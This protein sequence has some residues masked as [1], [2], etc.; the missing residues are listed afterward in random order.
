[1]SQARS[2]SKSVRRRCAPC[3]CRRAVIR[4]ALGWAL[5]G[6]LALGACDS[7]PPEPSSSF[8]VPRG[9]T[10]SPSQAST[11]VSSIAG[12]W[13]FKSLT[14]V[15]PSRLP[16]GALPDNRHDIVVHENG[17]FR[18]GQWSGSIKYVAPNF[19]MYVV[20]PG[21]LR[22]RFDRW[23]AFVVLFLDGN[24]LDVFLPDLGRDRDLDFGSAIED[25]D[26]PDMRFR[27]ARS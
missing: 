13:R 21:P 20:R 7:A 14:G 18:W 6:A 22:R 19:L 1:M 17:S 11:D 3:L 8:V 5:L 2:S 9:T 12:R 10:H 15:L 25:I 27:R 23:G 26:S 24:K 16:T 4:L